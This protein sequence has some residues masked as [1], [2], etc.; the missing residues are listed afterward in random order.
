[1]KGSAS[2]GDGELWVGMGAETEL[3]SR[4]NSKD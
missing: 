1:M 2:S 3:N 4:K